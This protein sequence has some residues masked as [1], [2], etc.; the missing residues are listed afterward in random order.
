[1]KPLFS[2]NPST[3]SIIKSFDQYSER[4]IYHIIDGACKVQKNW[5]NTDLDFRLACLERLSE[6]LADYK[7]EYA[8]LMAEEM[9][10]PFKQGISEIEKCIWLCNYFIGNSKKYLG[11]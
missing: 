10:K 3:D 9:G 5:K 1:M 2:V 4:K 11:Y 7:R 6:L 8:S